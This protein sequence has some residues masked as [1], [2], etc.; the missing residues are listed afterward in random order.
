MKQYNNLIPT[1]TY[2]IIRDGETIGQ[3][4]AHSAAEAIGLWK[5]HQDGQ[6]AHLIDYDLEMLPYKIYDGGEYITISYGH[7]LPEAYGRYI[8]QQPDWQEH[9]TVA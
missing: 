4:T 5:Y 1:R 9:Y 6:P 2:Q 7:S 8:R 3:E